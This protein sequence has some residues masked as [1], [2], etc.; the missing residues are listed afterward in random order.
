MLSMS[1]VLKL[2]YLPLDVALTNQ[3][4]STIFQKSSSSLILF[5]WLEKS[6]ILQV[7]HFKPCQLLSFWT[8]M[9]SLIE[10]MT[11]LLN[12][13]NAQVTSSRFFTIKL[14]KRPSLLILC[15]YFY[16]RIHGILARKMKVTTLSNIGR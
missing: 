1:Q 16:A 2:S 6:L 9:T 12:S 11:I 10:A 3:F 14:T 8:F 7:I 13:G 15:Y 5:I 4:V